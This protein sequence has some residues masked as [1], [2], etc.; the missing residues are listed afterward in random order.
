MVRSVWK[1]CLL[2]LACV[3]SSE[4]YAQTSFQKM[5]RWAGS[6]QIDEVQP[7]S[8]GNMVFSGVMDGNAFIASADCNGSVN[9]SVMSTSESANTDFPVRTVADNVGNRY[10]L[11]TS[12]LALDESLDVHLLKM[13]PDTT[14][15]WH[16]VIGGVKN[17]SAADLAV[18]ADGTIVIGGTTSSF[19]TDAPSGTF[20]DLFAI[21]FQP[22]GEISWRHTYGNPSID[23]VSTSLTCS[24]DGSC[25]ISGNTGQ[26]GI[27]RIFLLKVDTLGEMVWYKN[28]GNSNHENVVSDIIQLPTSELLISGSTSELGTNYSDPSTACTWMISSM[29]GSIISA[30]A[31]TDIDGATSV[32]TKCMVDNSGDI[33]ASAIYEGYSSYNTLPDTQKAV[34]LKW[35]ETGL[36]QTAELLTIAGTTDMFIALAADG[37]V[38][39]SI[40]TYQYSNP[41][42]NNEV[43]LV[44]TDAAFNT[45]CNQIDVSVETS[46]IPLS[47]MNPNTIIIQHDILIDVL[48]ANSFTSVVS[49]PVVEVLCQNAGFL[50]ANFTGEGGCVDDFLAF[51]DQSQGNILTWNWDFG[52]GN[53]SSF[54]DPANSYESGGT[55]M[56]TLTV[57]DGCSEH[58]DSLEIEVDPTPVADAGYDQYI[59]IGSSAVIGILSEDDDLIYQWSPPSGVSPSDAPIGTVSPVITTNYTLTVSNEFGCSSSDNVTVFVDTTPV[60]PDQNGELYV[61]NIFSP[62]DD[63]QNDVFYVYG[64][65]FTEF[66]LAIF[67]RLGE[68]AFST[69]DQE[70]GWDGRFRGKAAP[71]GAYYYQLSLIDE[72]GTEVKT[73]GNITLTR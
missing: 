47:N 49:D 16:K 17:D 26:L 15:H 62:N 67:N 54:Q 4:L 70:V 71:I 32:I 1:M 2:Y 60:V 58:V 53:I 18:R 13:G 57:S 33:L 44:K 51:E 68:R 52:D 64:G 40:N 31:Y 73:S 55:Y 23:D 28:Y 29:D 7:I 6:Y 36:F 35:D 24:S 72:T 22:N 61:P 65:P 66:D 63:G 5:F 43:L 46:A 19:G 38:V 50:L 42:C 30:N 69:V 11:Y 39:A 48:N 8:D 45:G 37:T 9:W 56:V 12:G 41:C 3:G 34:M 14:I 21:C 10:V 59:R 25:Y 27:T 20:C